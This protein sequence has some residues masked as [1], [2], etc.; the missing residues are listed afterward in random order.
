LWRSRDSLLG[1][2]KLRRDFTAE[3]DLGAM[4]L[5]TDHIRCVAAGRLGQFMSTNNDSV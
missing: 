4:L 3:S 1:I 5:S 2:V